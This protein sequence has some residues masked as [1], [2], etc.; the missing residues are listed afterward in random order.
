[1]MHDWG[2]GWGWGGGMFFGPLFMIG[3]PV[4]L[5]I[6]IVVLVRWLTNSRDSPSVQMRTPRE[7]LDERFAK[8]E[9]QRDEY[10]ERRKALGA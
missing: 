9:I 1:M 4:L 7:I 8:G 6:L 3:G 10:E 2:Y 5:I